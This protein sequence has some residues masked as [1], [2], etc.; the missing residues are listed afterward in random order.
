MIQ[1]YITQALITPIPPPQKRKSKH[2]FRSIKS[3]D[4]SSY[5]YIPLISKYKLQRPVQ[6]KYK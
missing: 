2:L 5:I 3:S 6:L 1:M 4:L